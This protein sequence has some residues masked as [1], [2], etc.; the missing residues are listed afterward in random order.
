ML[1]ILAIMAALIFVD[2][3][4]YHGRM[5]GRPAA[6]ALVYG[7]HALHQAAYRVGM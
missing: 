5:I 7:S 3:N 2:A 6:A 1:R 4:W